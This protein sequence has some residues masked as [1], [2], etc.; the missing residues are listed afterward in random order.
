MGTR[1]HQIKVNQLSRLLIYILGH[2]PDE[3]GLVPDLDGFVVYKELI[4]AIHEEPGWSYVRR[5]HINEVLLGKNR[6]LFQPEE[7]RIRVLERRW[8]LDF[9]DAARSPGR[10]RGKFSYG[11]DMDSRQKPPKILYIP[12]RRRAHPVV[13]EKGLKSSEG[14]YL[15]LSAEEDMALR[16]GKR[17]DQKPVLLEIMAWDAEKEG[18]LLYPFG[19]LFLTNQIPAKYI[20]GPPVSK[21]VLE[22]RSDGG[23][24]EERVRPVASN[25][26]PGTFSLD[27][28]RDTGRFQKTKGKKRKGWKEEARNLRKRKGR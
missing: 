8:R 18:V 4:Q 19:N 7:N 26:T 21:E 14:R 16:I 15:A 24:R 2:R 6:P 11:Q 25:L 20:S 23:T 13:M 1:N 17:R 28:A 12:V 9:D 3:F 27:I 10:P 5:S 22:R